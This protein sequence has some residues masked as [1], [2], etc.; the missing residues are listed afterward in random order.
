MRKNGQL[1]KV[2]KGRLW[3]LTTAFL[4]T[5]V[6]L[7]LMYRFILD[8]YFIKDQLGIEVYLST[9][10]K[11]II[12][13]ISLFI[14]L[15]INYRFVQKSIRIKHLL[16]FFETVLLAFILNNI[17]KVCAYYGI[18]LEYLTPLIIGFT[19]M[20]IIIYLTLFSYEVLLYFG[21]EKKA[22]DI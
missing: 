6:S 3:V 4:N 1:Y 20:S 19:L 9:T 21:L 14:V 2:N 15:W 11:Y 5:L 13:C 22:K 10:N 16:G 8:D 12:S 17:V 18:R 7:Y